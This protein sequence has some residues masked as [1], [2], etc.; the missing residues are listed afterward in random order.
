M[1]PPNAASVF[2]AT[3]ASRSEQLP[4]TGVSGAS[5]VV[6]TTIFA[7]AAVPASPRVSMALVIN[8]QAIV[9]RLALL[10]MLSYRAPGC[11]RESR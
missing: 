11:Y 5:A 4:G 2:A 9:R 7:A 8:A 6:S 1:Q 3:V 10:R